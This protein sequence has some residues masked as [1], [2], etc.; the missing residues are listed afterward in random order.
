M[1]KIVLILGNGF[2]LD[3]GLKSTYTQYAN[4]AEWRDLYHNR[5]KFLVKEHGNKKSLLDQIKNAQYNAWFD[6]EEEINT[7]VKKQINVDIDKSIIDS[8]KKDFVRLKHSLKN[9]LSR[10][11]EE[12]KTDASRLSFIILSALINHNQT[13]KQIFTFNYTDCFKMCKYYG[14]YNEL[15][16]YTHIHGSLDDDVVLGCEV[17]DGN[18]INRNYSFLYKYNMLNKPNKIVKNLMEAKEVVFFGHSINEMDFCY[19]KEYFK[20]ASTTVGRDKH[21]TIICKDKE[22]EI[23]IKDNIRS[24]GI[25]VTDLYNNLDVFDFIHTD[26]VYA[27]NIKENIKWNNLINRIK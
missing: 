27:E 19:F 15:F 16:D 21:L 8:N 5:Q 17:Y 18:K 26:L 1:S 3:L 13:N 6:L 24:Q 9:Y 10:I 7:F 12:Y 4:S 11:S 25:I 2:D 20:A 23:R 14:S 22:S